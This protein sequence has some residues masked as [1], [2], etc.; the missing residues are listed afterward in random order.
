MSRVGKKPISIPAGVTVTINDS[1]LEV[2]GPKGTLTTPVPNGVKFTQ[3]DGALVAERAGDDLAAFHGLARALANNAVVG[4]TE[5][6]KK[7]MDVVGVGYKADVQGKKIVFA[8]GYSH[9]VEYV[10]PDGIEAKAERVGSKTSINQYQLTITLTGIDKQKLGQV[11][12]ELNRL[13]KPDAYKGKG[14]RYADKV[15]K[16]KPGKTGK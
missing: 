1:V 7:E 14:V 16:L 11:A 9:P 5:G 4:V 10:L 3:E 12:A 13:R 8:L 15:Y 6:F 2:K